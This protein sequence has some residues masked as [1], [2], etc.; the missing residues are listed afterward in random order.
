MCLQAGQASHR[1]IC[2]YFFVQPFEQS[3]C[4]V[5][6]VWGGRGYSKRIAT[7]L[8]L[9][10]GMCSLTLK[11]EFT[12]IPNGLAALNVVP[13]AKKL[14][15]R[16]KGLGWTGATTKESL[17]PGSGSRRAYIRSGGCSMVSVVV[18]CW[19]LLGLFSK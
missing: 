2:L 3:S 10:P 15:L 9:P 1:L 5:P 8:P 16:R 11:Q 19:A 7:C 17:H 4:S 6:D 18:G 12:S 14:G 13:T